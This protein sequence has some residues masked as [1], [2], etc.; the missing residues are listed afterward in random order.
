[1]S[2]TQTPAPARSDVRADLSTTTGSRPTKGRPYLW[3]GT[4]LTAGA[5]AWSSMIMVFGF[6][7][8]ED[9]AGRIGHNTGAVLFQLGLLAL[10]RVLWRTRALGDGRLAR[11][12]I[13]V[14][15]V[16]LGLAICSTLSDLF[17]FTDLT[18]PVSL[19]LDFFWPISMLGMFS[20]GIRTTIAGR[21]KGLS[22]VWPV[23]AESWAVV[24]VPTMGIAGPGVARWVGAVHLLVGYAVLGQIVARKQ[25]VEG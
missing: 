12:A 19:A 1:M 15:V 24:T 13:R 22:R 5:V 17:G 7:R 3:H 14:E 9:T 21:W 10:L 20:I 11:A 25:A 16:V 2:L 8:L 18:N 6:D 23:I 4:L